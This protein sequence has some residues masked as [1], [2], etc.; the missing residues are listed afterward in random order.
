M[1]DAMPVYE[2]NDEQ[3]VNDG[4]LIPIVNLGLVL[5]GKP[6]DRVTRALWDKITAD[7]SKTEDGSFKN[8]ELEA[9]LESLMRGGKKDSYI[10]QFTTD[11]GPVWAELNSRGRWTLM[12]P[13]DH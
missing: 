6:V 10:Y 3:A 7:L 13:S 8:V 12:F 9:R 5:D 11:Y 1:T 2:Y 4:L